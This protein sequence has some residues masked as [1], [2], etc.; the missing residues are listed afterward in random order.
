M[1]LSH[2]LTSKALDLPAA[3]CLFFASHSCR[4]SSEVNDSLGSQLHLSIVYPAH[5]TKYSVIKIPSSESES[6][7]AYDLRSARMAFTT[8]SASSSLST[9][10]AKESI[11]SSLSRSKT[12]LI[13]DSDAI[14]VA[15]QVKSTN[16][17]L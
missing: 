10:D 8:Y 5:S 2:D 12:L 15:W 13:S 17:S 4:V 14:L 6:G 9:V 1:C 7:S 16:V 3:I 11:S